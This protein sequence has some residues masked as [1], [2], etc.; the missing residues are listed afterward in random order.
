MSDATAL[1]KRGQVTWALWRYATLLRGG[2]SETPP[3]VF[4]SRVRRLIEL[5][6]EPANS[7]VDLDPP[8][9]FFD[10]APLGK[11][12]EITFSSFNAFTLAIG[13][14]M[15]DSGMKQSETVFVLKHIRAD[16][17]KWFRKIRRRDL[18][19]NRAPTKYDPKVHG[20]LRSIR[21]S[22]ED[23]TRVIDPTVF[24]AIRS[25]DTNAIAAAPASELKRAYLE[26]VF[27]DGGDDLAQRISRRNPHIRSCL[28]LELHEPAMCVPSFLERAPEFPR[29][30]P[31]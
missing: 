21:H 12:T 15:L 6:R 3:T 29:G 28:L 8:F 23:E 30:R 22:D 26:P 7:E 9:A 5:D 17:Q 19:V 31:K 18:Q 1:Y 14:E 25:V 20:G 24:L 4:A 13:F 2:H 10:H 16:L 27:F 11:G